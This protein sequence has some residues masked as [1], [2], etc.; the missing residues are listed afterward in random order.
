M[1]RCTG[2]AASSAPGRRRRL[3]AG[4]L[5]QHIHLAATDAGLGLQHLNQVTE[6]IARDRATGNADRFSTRWAQ[7]TGVSA[8]Q[9]LLAF[10]SGHPVRAAKPSPRRALADVITARA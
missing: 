4:R 8:D 6:R 9:G 3:A 10:R 5:L 1:T 2:P 7:A